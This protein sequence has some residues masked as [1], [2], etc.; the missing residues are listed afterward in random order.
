MSS[1]RDGK[2]LA[3]VSRITKHYLREHVLVSGSKMDAKQLTKNLV[4]LPWLHLGH[5]D[6]RLACKYVDALSEGVC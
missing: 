5:F 1:R 6:S 3:S 2:K 4:V